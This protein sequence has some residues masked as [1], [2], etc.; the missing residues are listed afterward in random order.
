MLTIRLK[1]ESDIIK[2]ESETPESDGA[3]PR[4]HGRPEINSEQKGEPSP[5][6]K[7]VI[8]SPL[9]KK[10]PPPKIS[11]KEE[12]PSNT[13]TKKKDKLKIKATEVKSS[14][15]HI[16]L[17][18]HKSKSQCQITLPSSSG[19]NL[20]EAKGRPESDLPA[21]KAEAPKILQQKELVEPR[22]ETFRAAK[23]PKRFVS[24]LQDSR[25]GRGDEP[26]AKDQHRSHSVRERPITKLQVLPVPYQPPKP[27]QL[28]DGANA[29]FLNG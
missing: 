9:K 12:S 14:G 21:Q 15:A 22:R 13:S 1:D 6:R 18:K 24:D 2:G 27:L 29:E 10:A 26:E 4:F 19:A 5:K 20:N 23:T 25:K 17:N 8:K 28:G 7:L 16:K 11:E 3:L